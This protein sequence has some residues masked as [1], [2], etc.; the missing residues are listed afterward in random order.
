MKVLGVVNQDFNI[1]NYAGLINV[2]ML[3]NIPIAF[4]VSVILFITVEHR[5]LENM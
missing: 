1:M 4:I 5:F 3:P 2:E